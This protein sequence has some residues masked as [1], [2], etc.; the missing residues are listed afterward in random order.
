MTTV[1]DTCEKG[2]YM[3]QVV[4]IGDN[5]VPADDDI[6]DI[7]HTSTAITDVARKY[8]A[9]V[10]AVIGKGENYHVVTQYHEGDT[11]IEED[12]IKAL[13]LI[14]SIAEAYGTT[15][16]DITQLILR[17]IEMKGESDGTHSEG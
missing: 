4:R 8:K 5:F 16:M 14:E 13:S 1:M 7:S 9:D 15:A 2:I 3:Q 11:K 17:I 10:L 6:K 12:I